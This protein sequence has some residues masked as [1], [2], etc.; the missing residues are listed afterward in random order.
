MTIHGSQINFQIL[1]MNEILP[2][3]LQENQT[4]TWIGCVLDTKETADL[5]VKEI[6]DSKNNFGRL[7]NQCLHALLTVNKTGKQNHNRQNKYA[8]YFKSSFYI[9]RPIISKCDAIR[10][11]SNVDF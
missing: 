7:V 9:I 1:L 4:V 2:G 10:Y 6:S 5:Y 3:K 8:Q 11:G